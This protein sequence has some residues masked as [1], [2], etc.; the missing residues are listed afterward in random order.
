MVS[1]TGPA[2]L[3]AGALTLRELA[4]RA[5]LPPSTVRHYLRLGLLP[6][7]TRA[8]SGAYRFAERHVD[9]LQLVRLLQARR[10]LSLAQIG[11]VLN[12]T[13]LDAEG[14]F[15]PS[16]WQGL[17][18]TA[19]STQPDPRQ[20]LVDAAL[21]AFG[22]QQFAEVRVE[23]LCRAAG[24]AK[25]SFY[26]YFRAKDEVFFA[27][28]TAVGDEAA[29]ALRDATTPAAA[30]ER[31]RTVFGARL[32]VLLELLS[33]AARRQPG[34]SRAAAALVRSLEEAVTS[35]VGPMGAPGEERP[36]QALVADALLGAL[37][38]LVG[39]PPPHATRRS[40]H[41]RDPEP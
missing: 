4:R 15:R 27:A 18:T 8:A 32:P 16:M 19:A 13:G 39:V 20:R 28:V 35:S 12:T 14:A 23:D 1:P 3:S 6:P 21:S 36:A 34:H 38:P 25:G 10:G 33:L 37:A 30:T 2:E 26:R 11:A 9:A 41:P 17:V 5:G 31:L 7:A 24:I 22:R 29:R 40:P